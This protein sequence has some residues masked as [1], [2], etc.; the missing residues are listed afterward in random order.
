[1]IQPKKKQDESGDSKKGHLPVCT[2]MH[3]HDQGNLA[4][5]HHPHPALIPQALTDRQFQ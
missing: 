1:M 2:G 4:P 3:R 5:L